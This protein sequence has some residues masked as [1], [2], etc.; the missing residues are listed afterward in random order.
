[1]RRRAIV[2]TQLFI[3]ILTWF[4]KESG[5][6]GFQNTTVPEECPKPLFMEDQ[7][8]TNTTDKWVNVN[9]ETNIES[10]TY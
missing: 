6:P 7:E 8:T 2:D 4:V 3:D 9:V 1:V 5:H 10:G